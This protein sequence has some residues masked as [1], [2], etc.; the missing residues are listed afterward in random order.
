[1]LKLSIKSLLARKL[2]F[3]MTSI[4]VVLGVTFVVA[5]FV[6]TDSLRDTFGQ[7]SEDVNTGNDLIVRQV[8]EFGD[9]GTAATKVPD[10]LVSKIQAVPGV[11]EAEGGL[12][13]VNGANPIDGKGEAVKT[14]GPPLA[15]A[16]WGDAETLNNFVL[17]SG[18]KPSGPSEFAIG[19][20]TAKDYDF[21]LGNKYTLVTKA[22]NREMTL[23]GLHQFGKDKNAAVGA[24]VVLFDNATTQQLT[25]YVDSYQEIWINIKPGADRAQVQAEVAKL[26]PANVEVV[27]NEVATDEFADSFN[28]FIGPLRT[29]LLVFALIVAFVAAFIINNTF[30]IVLGQ[31]VRELGLMRALGATGKQVRRSVI[32]ESAILG[33]LATV[34]GIGLGL[35]GALGIKGIFSAAGFSLP[36]GSLPLRPV[37]I[38]AAAIVGI[39]TTVVASLIPAFKAARTPPI[40]ALRE[41]V[42]LT[43]STARR[44]T[45]VGASITF[46]GVIFALVGLVGGG[47][48]AANKLIALGLGAVLVF[49]GVAILSPLVAR[50]VSR[51][52]GAVLP[53]FFGKPGQLA[54]ENAARN[55]RRTASTA[56]ALMIGLALVCMVSV[57]GSSLKESFS[58]TLD[59][60]VKAD[61][62]VR[63]DNQASI[64]F[65]PV[66][67]EDL[68]ALPG[69]G[70]VAAMR[71]QGVIQIDGDTKQLTAVDWSTVGEL[72]DFKLQSGDPS[73]AT[74]NAIMIFED[75]AKDRNVKVGDTLPIKFQGRDIEQFTIAGIYGDATIFGN[76]VVD[77]ATWDKYIPSELDFFVS[78][79]AK[80]GGDVAALR[81]SVEQ[82]VKTKYPQLKVENRAE[83][84]ESQEQ[85]VDNIFIVVNV[86]LMI[87]VIIALV[88]IINTLTLS[89]FERT[90]E[91]GLMRAVGMTRR[92]LKRMIRWESVIIAVFGGLLG[93]AMGIIFGVA[94]SI[95]IPDSIISVTKVPVGQIVFFIVLSGIAGLLAA[96]LPARRAAKL[97]VLE[98]VSHL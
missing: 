8:V 81:E 38:I 23:V 10:S 78:L 94:L 40:A 67:T 85:Q 43:G 51:T 47:D 42:R 98:A 3:I 37:T 19:A 50:P 48:S 60:S 45:I 31:R 35:L 20:D 90:R 49:I 58:R 83:F 95:A 61:L 33:L 69:A 34:V 92:Q 71:F 14:V 57:L 65:S 87:A 75:V 74:G 80:P 56:S 77:L 27:T 59:T 82:L 68:R 1:M 9:R 97:N 84:R 16:N 11:N 64:G 89:I 86:F 18:R 6:V 21:Q 29:I 79:S 5:S 2:R 63:E 66:V 73:K 24:V 46:V 70:A 32:V 54:R 7:L 15:A 41:D 25:G 13:V 62:L 44:R 22:G 26:L 88:G 76:Y 72:F 52:L 91:I 17:K 4:A 30:N 53:R 39:G 36:Q 55:P 12:F 28:V 93:A 96:L